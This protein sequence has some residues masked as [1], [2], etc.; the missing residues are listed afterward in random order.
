MRKVKVRKFVVIMMS[1]LMVAVF[2]CPND[3]A[4]AENTSQKSY[5]AN[6]KGFYQW[7]ADKYKDDTGKSYLVEDANSA[8]EILNKSSWRKYT[9][10]GKHRDA[11]SL[12]SMND[13][14]HLYSVMEM[15]RKK[16]NNFKKLPPMY[17]TNELVARA[18]VNANAS[19]STWKHMSNDNGTS[20]GSSCEC[21]AWGY[22]NY[23]EGPFRG[24]YHTEKVEYNKMRKYVL[25]KYNVDM[26]D[27]SQ[28]AKFDEIWDKL[29]KD[30]T[31]KSFGEIGHYRIVCAYRSKV[32]DF[33]GGG[34]TPKIY[35]KRH[36]AIQ[37]GMAC[38]YSCNSLEV[39]EAKASMDADGK[40]LRGYTIKEYKTL[41]KQ[42]INECHPEFYT[43]GSKQINVSNRVYTG[44]NLKPYV[45]I[46]ANDTTLINGTDYKVKYPKNS[47]KIGTYKVV[48]YGKGKYP[49]TVT[50][51]FKIVP[52]KPKIKSIK[53]GKR[54]ATIKLDKKTYK[55]G[56]THF[57]IRYRLSNSKTWK[58]I[59]TKSQS[60]TIR[61]LKKGKRYKIQVRVYKKIGKTTYNSSWSKTKK[62]ARVI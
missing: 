28:V 37:V 4:F 18:Q 35:I 6:S 39:S 48:I 5:G 51:S 24:W 40:L 44:K 61:K 29:Q 50:R 3:K 25:K 54:R 55:Y 56:G 19:A 15:L 41:F 33:S 45:W 14:M 16:D 59:T 23:G 32:I 13:I 53:V 58:T 10:L 20:K 57:E 11:T 31:Y 22:G 17:V 21:L 52:A 9:K 1:T 46:N 7:I 62:T 49:G 60:K 2:L 42:F 30:K 27:D 36:K 8:L 43:I 12:D 26:N 34:D 47:K 38:G